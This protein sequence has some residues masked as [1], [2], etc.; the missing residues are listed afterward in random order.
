MPAVVARTFVVHGLVQGVFFRGTCV[1]VARGLGVRGWVRNEYDGTVRAHVEG[2]PEA[3]Q[4]M[5]SWAR[6]GPRHAVVQRLDVTEVQ[7]EGF[8]DFEVC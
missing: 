6:Q 3:V 5:L 4:A 8:D 7:P 2:D 1:H